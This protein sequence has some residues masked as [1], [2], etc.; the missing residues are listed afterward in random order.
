MVDGTSHTDAE[1]VGPDVIVNL[2]FDDYGKLIGKYCKYTS[3][4][5]DA[6]YSLM[7]HDLTTALRRITIGVYITQ[8]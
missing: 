1:D 2:T 8:C 6:A 3:N 5:Y 4:L 7:L